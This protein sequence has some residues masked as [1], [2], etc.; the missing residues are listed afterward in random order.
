MSVVLLSREY[1][2]DDNRQ[3]KLIPDEETRGDNRRLYW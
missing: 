2:V 1:F 3:R